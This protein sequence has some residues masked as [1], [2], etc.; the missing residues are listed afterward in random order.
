MQNESNNFAELL[1]TI[2][3]VIGERPKEA[4]CIAA[5]T[6]EAR[7][8]GTLLIEIRELDKTRRTLGIRPEHLKGI[9]DQLSQIDYD[10]FCVLSYVD[11]VEP[12]CE[13]HPAMFH[14]SQYIGGLLAILT[15]KQPVSAGIVTS[16]YFMEYDDD[17][18]EGDEFTAADWTRHPVAE[19]DSSVRALEMR[20]SGAYSA[21]RPP[22]DPAYA[23]PEMTKAIDDFAQSFPFLKHWTPENEACREARALF[24]VCIGRDF[25]PTEPEAVRMLGYMQHPGIRD[26]LLADIVTTDD[27]RETYLRALTGRLDVSLDQ[28]RV[29]RATGLFLNLTQYAEGDRRIPLIL[30]LSIVSWFRGSA[31]HAGRYV[32]ILTD[33]YPEERSL[34]LWANKLG[35]GALAACAR[36]TMH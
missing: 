3:G 11:N 35:S 5:F 36:R 23:T 2:D 14:Q 13:D 29:E 7:L 16:E 8:V 26:R 9:A 20:A 19:I 1:A 12:D 27:D 4:I 15:G 22:L 28:G 17:M 24:E 31:H 18:P 30:A 25:G 32:A 6:A 34:Q 21:F 33:L 10:C